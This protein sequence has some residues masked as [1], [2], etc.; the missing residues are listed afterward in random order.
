MGRVSR[1]TFVMVGVDVGL[2]VG[3]R[4]G[5]TIGLHDPYPSLMEVMTTSPACLH[6][7]L[8]AKNVGAYR[9]RD[10]VVTSTSSGLSCARAVCRAVCVMVCVPAV[11]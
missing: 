1:L 11:P 4:V 10:T 5:P 9:R 6:L 7:F 2:G 8:R 3:V